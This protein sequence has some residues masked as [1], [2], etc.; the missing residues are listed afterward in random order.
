M[1]T[2]NVLK[3]GYLVL[4]KLRVTLHFWSTCVL[5][6]G[7]E[8]LQMLV[9]KNFFMLKCE[10]SSYL[11]KPLL[12]HVCVSLRKLKWLRDMYFQYKTYMENQTFNYLHQGSTEISGSWDKS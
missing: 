1:G 2:I 4:L 7:S 9:T 10:T 8:I 5:R 11:C 6:V 3:N 12:I